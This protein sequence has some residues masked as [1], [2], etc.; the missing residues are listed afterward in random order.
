MTA[1][2]ALEI[3]R[4]NGLQVSIHQAKSILKLIHNLVAI[5][6]QKS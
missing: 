3:L 6:M 1:E 5:K 4:Q 2:K